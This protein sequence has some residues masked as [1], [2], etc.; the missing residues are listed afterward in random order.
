MVK[1]IKWLD[2]PK[3][4]KDILAKVEQSKVFDVELN[5]TKHILTA[6]L[7]R[8][9]NYIR[10]GEVLEERIPEGKPPE[11]LEYVLAQGY[12]FNCFPPTSLEVLKSHKVYGKQYVAKPYHFAYELNKQE[13]QTINK[14]LEQWFKP[15]PQ[16]NLLQ[17]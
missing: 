6:D 15:L 17:Q 1:I 7:N 11:D 14:F 2:V 3:A 10:F 5:L 16:E 8:L 12:N 9:K 4:V 13:L